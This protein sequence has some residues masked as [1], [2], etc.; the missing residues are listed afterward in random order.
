MPQVFKV[1]G[2]IVYFWVNE[3]VPLE[4]IHVHV[5]EGVPCE[6]G[7]KIWLT[8]AGKTL[9]CHNKSQVPENK[10]KTICELIESRFFESSSK[11]QER[12][13]TISYYC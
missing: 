6:N 12:F 11:W 9:L 10:L 4:P 3:G 1:G 8:K 5:A 2:F 13:N 7:T